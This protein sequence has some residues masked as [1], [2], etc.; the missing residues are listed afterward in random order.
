MT[1]IW[2][3]GGPSKI[4]SSDFKQF[5]QITWQFVCCALSLWHLGDESKLTNNGGDLVGKSTSD[6]DVRRIWRPGS[7]TLSLCYAIGCSLVLH[8]ISQFPEKRTN[9]VRS[10]GLSGYSSQIRIQIQIQ[11]R[12][13]IRKQIGKQIRI[14]IWIQIQIQIKLSEASLQYAD[15]EAWRLIHCTQAIRWRQFSKNNCIICSIFALIPDVKKKQ[16]IFQQ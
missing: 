4:Y 10:G 13:Q 15:L 11:I 8:S 14:Q 3:N 9:N 5:Q 6:D 1:S 2:R 16:N 7:H 12:I